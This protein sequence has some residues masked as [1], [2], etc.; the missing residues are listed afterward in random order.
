ML[1]PHPTPIDTIFIH[2]PYRR[3]RQT[4]SSILSTPN[5]PTSSVDVGMHSLHFYPSL[6]MGMVFFFL[7][8]HAGL[9]G[10]SAGFNYRKPE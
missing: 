7:R 3:P 6:F 5:A 10:A 8:P 2:L 4:P 9:K 1:C